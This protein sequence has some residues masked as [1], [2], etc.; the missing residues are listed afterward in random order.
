MIA[1]TEVDR[2]HQTLRLPNRFIGIGEGNTKLI[3]IQLNVPMNSTVEVSF[4]TDVEEAVT[5]EMFEEILHQRSDAF[6][7]KFESTF[8]LAAK[9]Y[10][11]FYQYMGRYA[12]SNM[13]GSIGFTSGYNRIIFSWLNTMN[14]EGWI[15]REMI[16]SKE[17][18]ML[19]PSEFLLQKDSI[20]NPPMFFYLIQRFLSDEKVIQ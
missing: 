19:V 14:V 16:L 18:E 20:A 7:D 13:L 2:E 8:G 6:I 15:P 9:G 10:S 3:A 4:S 11:G 5:G 1:A 12:L 17:D